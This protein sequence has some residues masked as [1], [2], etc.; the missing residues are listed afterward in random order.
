MK[1]LRLWQDQGS[2]KTLEAREETVTAFHKI[3]AWQYAIWDIG[4]SGGKESTALVTGTEP[5][6]A[7]FQEP[8]SD[9]A[10]TIVSARLA[11]HHEHDH[12]GGHPHCPYLS[13]SS[14]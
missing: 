2:R 5:L 8:L 12:R 10:E 13:S 1:A 7:L 6:A 9:Y 14:T 4:E 11:T 3:D